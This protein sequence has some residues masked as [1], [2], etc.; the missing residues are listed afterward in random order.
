MN[1]RSVTT[2]AA[3]QPSQPAAPSTSDTPATTAQEAS[4]SDT[5]Q[6][7][8]NERMVNMLQEQSDVRPDALERA[9]SLA[10][11]PNYP[12]TDAIEGLAKMFIADSGEE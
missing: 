2:P 8:Q 12:G 1:I 10:A 6:P 9:K 3:T 7:A 11:D 4:S 5:F